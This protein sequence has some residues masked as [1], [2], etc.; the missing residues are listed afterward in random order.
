MT[1]PEREELFN[2]NVKL[3]YSYYNKCKHRFN[4]NEQEDILQLLLLKFW[5]VVQKYDE[6][7]WALST[8]AFVAF[9][10]LIARELYVRKRFHDNCPTTS[11]DAIYNNSK[12]EATTYLEVLEGTGQIQGMY[13]QDCAKQI[14]ESLLLK[15]VLQ[16][17]RFSKQ[18]EIV[19]RAFLEEKTCKE[20]SE[21]VGCSVNQVGSTLYT[22]KQKLRATYE[23]KCKEAGL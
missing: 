12:K 3:V 5:N 4:V 22:I 6:E 11:Y 18:Q 9:Q 8:V 2:E 10:R 1:Q 16:A 20:M 15:D 21:L 13:K 17:T 14:I 7:K 23:H 19:L